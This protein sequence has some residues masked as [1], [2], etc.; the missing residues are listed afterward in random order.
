M[1][2]MPKGVK[3]VAYKYN[4]YI[5]TFITFSINSILIYKETHT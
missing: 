1:H 3:M 5:S 4:F 2:E